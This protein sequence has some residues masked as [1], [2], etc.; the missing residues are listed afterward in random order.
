MVELNLAQLLSPIS[1]QA[2]VSEHLEQKPCLV[3]ARQPDRFAGIVSTADCEFLAFSTSAPREGWIHVV[4]GGKAEPPSNALLDAS[5]LVKLPELYRSYADGATLLLT[6][7][8]RRLPAVAELCRSLERDLIG[9]GLL[10]SKTVGANAYLTPPRSQGFAPHYDDHCVLV[11]QIEGSKTWQIYA[12]RDELPLD[13]CAGT[14]APEQLGEPTLE[15]ELR[16]GDVVY[17]PRGHLH[18]ARTSHEKSLHLTISFGFYTWCDLLSSLARKQPALRRALPPH[19]SQADFLKDELR[20]PLA[21]MT[22]IGAIND[23]LQSFARHMFNNLDSLPND[24]FVQME[25]LEAIVE[26]TVVEKRSDALAWVDSDG[27]TATL[28]YPGASLSGP[29]EMEPIL[30]FIA[31]APRFSAATLPS[32]EED[33]DRLGVVRGLVKDGFV[34]AI[35]PSKGAS[36]K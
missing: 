20:E 34:R 3:Q 21:K 31:E 32:L 26:E 7:L 27:A 2:F 8:Q 22:E 25:Q 16:A 30:R 1:T 10:L 35:T 29:A 28:H 33:Y 12:P 13:R 5:G 9:L 18:Q 14:F 4:A 15:A 24:G 6:R 11:L 23:T 19:G 17:I 36:T